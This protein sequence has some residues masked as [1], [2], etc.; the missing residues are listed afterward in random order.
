MT[1]REIEAETPLGKIKLRKG[2]DIDTRK[3]KPCV[4]HIQKLTSFRRF[5]AKT[6]VLH[7]DDSGELRIHPLEV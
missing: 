7:I 2:D 4:G 5:R 6:F 1:E 3:L